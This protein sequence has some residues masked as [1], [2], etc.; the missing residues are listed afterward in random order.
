MSGRNPLRRDVESAW[1]EAAVS[2]L[3]LLS[4]VEETAGR[5]FLSPSGVR[6]AGADWTAVTVDLEVSNQPPSLVELY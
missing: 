1:G 4:W 5:L 2:Q 6:A 3:I